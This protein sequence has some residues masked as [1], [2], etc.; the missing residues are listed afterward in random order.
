MA[1]IQYTTCPVCNGSAIHPLLDAKDYTVSGSTFAVWTCEDCGCG[2]TQSVPSADAIGP[3]YQSDKYISHSDTRKGLVSRLYHQV[4]KLTLWQKY[5]LITRQLGKATGTLLDVGTG[6]A[7]FPA[8]MQSKGWKVTALE[9]DAATRE[10]ASQLH[11]LEILAPEA[12][13]LMG[14][15]QYDVITLWHVLEHVHDLNGYLRQFH[16][17]LKPG[18]LLLIAVP[19]YTSY[20]ARVY[21]ACWAAYDV[22]RHLYHF[23]PEAM[24]RLLVRE[25]FDFKGIKPMWFDSFYVSLLSEQYRHGRPRFISGIRTGLMSNLRAIFRHDTCS[26]LIYMAQP[27]D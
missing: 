11:R 10:K 18:G 24:R 27:V 21:G 25:H 20:D 12:M 26:S 7:V 13:T 6:M 2:F 23:S 5:H 3:Y 22:P 4:R 17:L 9:P 14:P 8:F 15:H 19:N 1:I 16:T